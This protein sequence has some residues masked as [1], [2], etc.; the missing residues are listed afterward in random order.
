[1][2]WRRRNERARDERSE[3]ESPTDDALSVAPAGTLVPIR[4]Y[5]MDDEVVDGWTRLGAQRLSDLLNGED[6]L[7]VS[8]V[9]DDPTD[10]DW[11]AVERESMMLV[12]A[13]PHQS[14]RQLRVYRQKREVT[15][16]SAHYELQGTVHLIPGN[17]LDRTVLRTRQHFVPF[18]DATAVTV[19]RPHDPEE[20]QTILLN[21]VNIGD[22]LELSLLEG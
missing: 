2:F 15:A 20:N 12:V 13:P 7:G 17:R 5:T 18:T 16:R 8:R 4:I 19:A 21:I 10:S 3:E 9:P 11:Q 6:E 14:P 22:D 1:M